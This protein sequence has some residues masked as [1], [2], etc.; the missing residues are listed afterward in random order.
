M[1][2]GFT[3]VANNMPA[4][5]VRWMSDSIALG[6]TP[7]GNGTNPSAYT[8]WNRQMNYEIKYGP[9]G[10]NRIIAS[11]YA[12]SLHVQQLMFPTSGS[13]LIPAVGIS[14]YEGSWGNDITGRDPYGLNAQLNPAYIEFWDKAIRTIEDGDNWTLLVATVNSLPGYVNIAAGFTV[15]SNL[16]MGMPA[17]F[18]DSVGPFYVF[19]YGAVQTVDTFL[20]PIA[21]TWQNLSL[22]QPGP[23]WTAILATN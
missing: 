17:Q 4:A 16:R 18:V 3:A 14:F 15:P 19:N 20:G 12:W 8:E 1:T 6:P 9:R 13:S 2:S 11:P 22:A 23:K 21:P 5:F 10:S 7:L